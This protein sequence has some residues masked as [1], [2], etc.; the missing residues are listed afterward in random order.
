M[1]GNNMAFDK[2]RVLRVAGRT[3]G[4]LVGVLALVVAVYFA[5]VGLSYK[6]LPDN[7]ELTV[8]TARD[9]ELAQS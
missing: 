9:G 8:T 3:V 4:V 1:A 5:Y 2:K 7:L 6:R